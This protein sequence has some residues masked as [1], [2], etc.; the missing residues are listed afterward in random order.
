M[1]FNSVVLAV[2]DVVGRADVVLAFASAIGRLSGRDA[3]GGLDRVVWESGS[4]WAIVWEVGASASREDVEPALGGRLDGDVLFGSPVALADVDGGFCTAADGG[5]KRVVVGGEVAARDDVVRVVGVVGG[6]PRP[7]REERRARS[8]GRGRAVG[9]GVG[10]GR[11]RAEV[12]VEV[13]Q[14]L[15][16]LLAA[17]EVGQDVVV[18]GGGVGLCFQR[19]PSLSLSLACL[20]F[21]CVVWC[22]VGEWVE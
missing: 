21:L 9:R 17:V 7:R 8:V 20:Q 18:A 10:R 22:G 19:S 5:G 12:R 15:C 14:R 4:V 11:G 3:C 13:A 6:C 1:G 16:G 2:D